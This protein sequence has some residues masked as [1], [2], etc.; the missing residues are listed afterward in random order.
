M[1]AVSAD[2]TPSP[3]SQ[4]SMNDAALLPCP[5]CGGEANLENDSFEGEAHVFCTVCE[6]RGGI[7]YYSEFYPEGVANLAVNC[8]VSEW[9]TRA[10]KA[11]AS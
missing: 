1:T 11:V 5:F 9:N 3:D 4:S 2:T 8:V 6:A 10:S 7:A